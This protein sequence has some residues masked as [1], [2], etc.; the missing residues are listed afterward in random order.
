ML[1]AGVPHLFTVLMVFVV[2]NFDISMLLFLKKIKNKS[3]I[4]THPDLPTI[5]TGKKKPV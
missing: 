2:L 4:K 3:A 5:G 1:Y